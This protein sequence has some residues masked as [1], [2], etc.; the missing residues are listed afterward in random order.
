MPPEVD[1]AA[2]E[3]RVARIED[4][5]AIEELKARYCSI[6]DAD[7]DPD[8]IVTVFSE[9]CVWQGEGIGVARGHAELRGLFERFQ[10]D[11][12]YSQHMVMNPLIELEGERAHAVW[13]FF[14]AFTF[15]TS[16]EA[17]WLA[18]RYD[19]DYVKQPD[20]WRIQH[21]RIREPVMNAAYAKGWA[22]QTLAARGR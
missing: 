21:L 16:E 15:R 11:I 9:D 4:R 13:Y 2:L 20:G 17:R 12:A 22:K 18:A 14:G 19:E 1:L 8:R 3:R 10:Q 6:C 5:Q 7:H